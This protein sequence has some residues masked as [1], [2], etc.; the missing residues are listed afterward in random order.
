MITGKAGLNWISRWVGCLKKRQRG[1]AARLAPERQLGLW[2]WESGK[3]PS[4][5]KVSGRCP[6]LRAWLVSLL[7]WGLVR[8]PTDGAYSHPQHGDT[9]TAQLPLGIGLGTDP[10]PQ[11][12]PKIGGLHQGS[13][14]L[15][16]ALRLAHARTAEGHGATGDERLCHKS[17]CAPWPDLDYYF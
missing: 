9:G 7:R 16:S 2:E 12:P 15:Q 1:T 11:I 14:Q 6:T 4:A 5:S 10:P 13:S 3:S 17:F 8:A